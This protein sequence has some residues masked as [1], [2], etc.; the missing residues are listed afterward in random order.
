[1]GLLSFKGGIHPPH[2]KKYSE[3]Q[4]IEKALEPS[5]VTIP[6]RQH[7]GAPCEPAVEKGELVKVGQ[8]IHKIRK[9]VKRSTVD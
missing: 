5:V 1:M 4:A 2:A 6:L 7:I 8:V 9:T 3:H